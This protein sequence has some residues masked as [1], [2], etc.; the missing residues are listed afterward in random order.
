M[1]HEAYIV[2]DEVY[3]MFYIEETEIQQG[4]DNY[5]ILYRLSDCRTR[6]DG[7]KSK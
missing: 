2:M 1:K 5:K 4:N 3:R 6:L 7:V